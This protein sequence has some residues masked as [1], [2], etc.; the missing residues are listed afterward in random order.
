M[1]CL[2]SK[3]FKKQVLGLANLVRPRELVACSGRKCD[4]PALTRKLTLKDLGSQPKFRIEN[5]G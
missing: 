3:Q 4:T 2:K 1:E 5:K